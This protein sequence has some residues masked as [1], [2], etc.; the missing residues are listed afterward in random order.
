MSVR[1]K[2]WEHRSRIY[3]LVLVATMFAVWWYRQEFPSEPPQP[4]DSVGVE[5]NEEYSLISITGVTFGTV[6]YNV[7]YLDNQL[8]NLKPN[9]D[10][11]LQRFNESLSTYLPTSEISRF[12]QE[13]LIKYELPFF[14]P[15]LQASKL[16]YDQTGGAFDPTVG[17]LIDAWGFGPEAPVFPDSGLVDSLLTFVSFDSVFFDSISVCRLRSGIELSFSA[18][19]KG[20]GVDVVADYLRGQ[21]LENLFVEIGGEIVASGHFIQ[22]KP[23]VIGIEDPTAALDDRRPVVRV[24]L[25]DRGVATSGNYRNFYVRKGKRYAHTLD[26]NSGYPVEHSLLSATVFAS[27]CML[28]D[29]YATAFMV[30]GTTATQDFLAGHPELDAILIYD[31][32]QE[33]LSTYYT[34]GIQSAVLQ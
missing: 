23:W 22:D 31:N 9:I 4:E 5:V 15:V 25:R 26:P 20:Q 24:Q 29:A 19:A 2:L 10:S 32:G 27:N 16:V 12:N 8:R 34:E 1:S 28:A 33:A 7:Q 17:P 3:P 18:I 21:G 6:S 13:G 30:M 14:Y 11:V